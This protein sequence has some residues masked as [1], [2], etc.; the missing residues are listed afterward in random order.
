MPS[1]KEIARVR[2]EVRGLLG[3]AGF[4]DWLEANW[5][6]VFGNDPTALTQAI[7]RCPQP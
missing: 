6:R 3:D 2:D 4:F 1:H 5:Q 7:K